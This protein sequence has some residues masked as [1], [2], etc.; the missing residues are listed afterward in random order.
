MLEDFIAYLRATLAVTREARTTLGREFEMMKTFLSILQIRMGNRLQVDINLPNDLKDM[1]MPPMLLQPLIEN[2]IKHGLEPKVEGGNI[3]LQAER[4]GDQMRIC[5]ID[6]GMGFA[7][8][9]SN[10]IG[11]KNVRERIEKLYG[12][13]GSVLIEDNRPSGTRVVLTV[14]RKIAA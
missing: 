7:S 3:T 10:G 13:A 8:N 1:T 4:A 5:V 6:T 11:L 9:P 14:P 2:A 12:N